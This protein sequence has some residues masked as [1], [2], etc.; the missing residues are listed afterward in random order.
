MAEPITVEIFQHMVELAALEIDEK[1]AEYLR[2]ELN[3]QLKA[4]EELVAVPLDESTPIASHG[5]P[6]PPALSAELREDKVHSFPN[7][8]DIIDRAPETEE[9]Y[10]VVPEIPH[11]NLD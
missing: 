8:E 9:N 3:N 4:I 5:I 6:Y 1:E 7:S 11:E 10:F 2:K